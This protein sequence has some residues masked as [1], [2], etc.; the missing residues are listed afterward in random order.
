[1][2]L[3][4]PRCTLW[5]AVAAWS[6]VSLLA[7]VR[8]AAQP[9]EPLLGAGAEPA[10]PART[11]T[12]RLTFENDAL[13]GTDRGYTNGLQYSRMRPRFEGLPSWARPFLGR[14]TLCSDAA[15]PAELPPVDAE[16]GPDRGCY[17][18]N[19]GF[20]LGQLI[21]T[22]EDLT[23]RD[24]IAD[25]RP[26]AGWLYGGVVT[27]LIHSSRRRMHRFE[28]QIGVLGP[29]SQADEAQI[30][31]H[32][33]FGFTRPQGWA[34]QV[35]TRLGAEIE[36][37]WTYNLLKLDRHERRLFDVHLGLG[38]TAGN[39]FANAR[40]SLLGRIGLNLSDVF[41]ETI[42]PVALTLDD[43]E[44]YL[45]ARVVAKGVLINET[46]EGSPRHLLEIEELVNDL[47][48]GFVLRL[49]GYSLAYSAV[50]RSDEYR[51]GGRQHRYGSLSF[52]W[53]RS[54]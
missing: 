21:Y 50:T 27:E 46:I 26:Y 45:F 43:V 41:P 35:D 7:A 39:V 20:L 1:M 44:A 24:L 30:L 48:A 52:S 19:S 2:N 36:Y 3:D 6:A 47:V 49:G 37:D 18:V 5:T 28:A 14:F 15:P 51:P 29:E 4:P 12:H 16:E 17:R 32:E 53:H 10:A 31:V 33:A 11:A 38:A 22:P 40:A 8:L 34:N 42:E 9:D 25:D 23:R 13:I 54:F